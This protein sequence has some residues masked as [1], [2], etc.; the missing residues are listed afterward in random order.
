MFL[1]LAGPVVGA[2][3]LSVYQEARVS[4]PQYGGARNLGRTELFLQPGRGP[5]TIREHT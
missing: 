5:A 2:D 4:D 3:L 1:A